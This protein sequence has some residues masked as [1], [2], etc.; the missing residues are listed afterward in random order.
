MSENQH[1]GGVVY[2][3]TSGEYSDYRVLCACP[4]EATADRIAADV[5]RVDRYAGARVEELPVRSESRIVKYSRLTCDV[6]EDGT[7]SEPYVYES[8]KHETTCNYPP[9]T[10]EWRDRPRRYGQARELVVYGTDEERVR[11]V[12]SEKR[13]LAMSNPEMLFGDGLPE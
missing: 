2:V 13:A 10:V 5:N 4:D 3:V 7:A 1:E 8:L 11:Q 12:F 6:F 9:F